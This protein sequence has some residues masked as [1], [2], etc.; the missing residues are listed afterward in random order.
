MEADGAQLKARLEATWMSGDH[1]D[2]A[3][4]AR[5]LVPGALA[6]PSRLAPQPG[7]RLL[8]IGCGAGQLALPAARAGAEVTGVDIATNLV[9]QA[10][11]RAA[12]AGLAARFDE[13]DAED[14]P[15]P[16]EEFDVVVSL[17]GAR[18]AT[19][20]CTPTSRRTG[21]PATRPPKAAPRSAPDTSKSSRAAPR[22][23]RVEHA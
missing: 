22:P 16:D 12:D 5:C 1:G 23:R 11:A 19:P 7:E 8:D 13:G 15:Y 14:L 6:F 21:R 18:P 17:L 10:R 3:H 20:G 4:F 9:E 2:Q